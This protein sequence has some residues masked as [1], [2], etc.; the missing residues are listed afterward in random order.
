[1]D[2]ARREFVDRMFR[3]RL[4][5]TLLGGLG[6]LGLTTGLG[7]GFRGA[8]LGLGIA[9]FVWLNRPLARWILD[10]RRTGDAGWQPMAVGMVLRVVA[11]IAV[12]AVSW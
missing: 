1:V 3:A 2:D 5:W 11:L 12:V 10:A 4:S 6:L 9:G 7:V 8:L